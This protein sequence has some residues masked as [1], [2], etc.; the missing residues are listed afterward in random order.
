MC[1]IDIAPWE[2]QDPGQQPTG[3]AMIQY[4]SSGGHDSFYIGDNSFNTGTFGFNNL[5]ELIE[6]YTHK[7]NDQGWTTFEAHYM[8][9]N[10]CTTVP[11]K[12]VPLQDGFYPVH[13]GTI[14]EGGIVN[15]TM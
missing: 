6:S 13:S 7:I 15:Y 14:A 2:T 11:T 1:G 4:I 9:M 3:T 8:Y 10:H 12:S 5:Q